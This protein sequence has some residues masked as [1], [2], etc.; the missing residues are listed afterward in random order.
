MNRG[1]RKKVE[2]ATIT[3]VGVNVAALAAK[4]K[5]TAVDL[6]VLGAGAKFP[7]PPVDM[8]EDPFTRLVVDTFRLHGWKA[9]HFEPGKAVS[10]RWITV[11]YGDAGFPD[12]VAARAGRVEWVETKSE[13]GRLE[14]NQKAWHEA[15]GPWRVRIWKPKDW[16]EILKVMA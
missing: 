6:A 1:Q 16:D 2:A 15:I 4:V 8:P 12:I 11:L 5:V 14:P 10:K 3:S 9:V 7:P 13:T